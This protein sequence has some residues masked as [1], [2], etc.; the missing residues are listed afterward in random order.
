MTSSFVINAY[1][2]TTQT[3]NALHQSLCVVNQALVDII[4]FL[5]AYGK[6]IYGQRSCLFMR[7][8]LL[9]SVVQI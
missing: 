3:C 7:R 2:S 4:K 9:L 1:V 5:S 8:L 6:Y